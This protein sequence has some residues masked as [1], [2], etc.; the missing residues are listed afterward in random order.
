MK[1]KKETLWFLLESWNWAQAI[2]I[3]VGQCCII[4]RE[5]LS[6]T[7]MVFAVAILSFRSVWKIN[8]EICSWRLSGLKSIS[9]YYKWPLL[10]NLE[11]WQQGWLFK[12][13]GRLK[14][15][16]LF[17][18]LD[19]EQHCWPA[20]TSLLTWVSEWETNSQLWSSRGRVFTTVS[21]Y[22]LDDSIC[23]CLPTGLAFHCQ[24]QN[25]DRIIHFVNQPL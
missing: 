5:K 9:M 12:G 13:N 14:E 22:I 10:E 19:S 25:D 17:L 2:T 15:Q 7:S 6:L 21:S 24:S 18:F 23:R 20:S 1:L 8:G 4:M 11:N 16:C 3:T